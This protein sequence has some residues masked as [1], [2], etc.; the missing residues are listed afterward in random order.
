ML[1]TSNRRKLVLEKSIRSNT[2]KEIINK[3]NEIKKKNRKNNEEE[4]PN[5]RKKWNKRTNTNSYVENEGK[6]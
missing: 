2:A 5:Q 4:V 6:L 1:Q 3:I